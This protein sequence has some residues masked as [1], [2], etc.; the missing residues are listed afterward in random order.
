MSGIELAAAVTDFVNAFSPDTKAFANAILQEHKTLQQSTMR[1][2]FE[3]IR[4]MAGQNYVDDRNE[5]AVE[6]CKRII[7]QFDDELYLP[8]I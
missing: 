4:A 8:L 7:S 3:L 6:M 1:L 2:V 5:R